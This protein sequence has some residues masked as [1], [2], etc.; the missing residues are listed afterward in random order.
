MNN[1][2][3]SLDI[4]LHLHSQ[5][6][7]R[8]HEE[9][10]PLMIASGAGVSV[11]DDAGKDYIEGMSGLWCASLGFSNQRLASVAH[12]QMSR[13]GFYHTANHRSNAPVTTLVG[14]MREISNITPCKIY[15]T[16]SGSEANDTMVKLAWYYNNARGKPEKRKIISRQ[17]AYHGSTIM[18]SALSGLPHMHRSFNLPTQDVVF[19]TKPSQFHEGRIGETP[20][21][22]GRRLAAELEALI[23]SEGADTIAAMIAE[24]VMGGGGVVIPPPNYFPLVQD[25]LK[26]NDIL[27][28]ADEIICGFGRTGNWFGA[29]TFGFQ[30]DMMSVAKGL[31]AGHMPI[32]AVIMSNEIYEGIADEAATIGVFGHGFTYSGHPVAAAVAAETLRIY[33]EMDILT[34]VR[35]L[36]NHLRNKLRSELAGHPN[37]GEIR[38]VG[39][40]AG[41]ELV[42]SVSRRPFDP[43]TKAGSQVERL[44]RSNG[45]IAR[46]MGDTIAVCP[47]F[48]IEPGEIDLL[49]ERLARSIEQFAATHEPASA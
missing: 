1:A 24:P 23:Q 12:E 42:D 28:M 36:G 2:S 35:R 9:D 38:S 33:R 44:C 22:F 32:A 20:E 16:G 15:F 41:I 13:L 37:V 4:E 8:V 10:G 3:R 31:S 11:T 40:L 46:N 17:G 21:A 14:L 19:A 43:M 29:Q 47:P 5:T 7:P 45:V 34:S 25:I 30:P 26:R 49:V 48:V 27:L 6:N 18:A 39:L